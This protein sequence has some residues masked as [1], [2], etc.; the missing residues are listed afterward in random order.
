M[1]YRNTDAS[2]A[3]SP[4]HRH[5]PALGCR[6]NQPLLKLQASLHS[7]ISALPD[8]SLCAWWRLHVA[9]SSLGKLEPG[10][11]EQLQSQSWQ[12][13]NAMCTSHFGAIVR[14]THVTGTVSLSKRGLDVSSATWVRALSPHERAAS[15][16]RRFPQPYGPL[17]AP[18]GS[19]EGKARAPALHCEIR[20]AF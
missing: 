17:R 2:L 3:Y 8:S 12:P 13:R 19:T 20:R 16:R 4:W 10:S 6:L 7:I 9:Y 5:A 1:E 14:T 11:A 15:S 18:N